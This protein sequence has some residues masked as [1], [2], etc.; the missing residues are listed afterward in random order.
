MMKKSKVMTLIKNELL[1]ATQKMSLTER[2]NAFYTHSSLLTQLFE[3]GKN[4]RTDNCNYKGSSLS[5]GKNK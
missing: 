2:I 4:Y 3:A 5:S 1:L